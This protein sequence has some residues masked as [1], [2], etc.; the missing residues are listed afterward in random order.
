MYGINLINLLLITVIMDL[1]SKIENG[2]NGKSNI[3]N[4]RL[5]R[6]I[7]LILQF[8]IIAGP[9]MTMIDTSVVNI[10]LPEMASNFSVTLSVVQWVLSAYLLT[11][12]TFLVLS[13]YLSKRFGAIKVYSTSLIGF[14]VASFFCAVSPYLVVLIISRV[15][16]GAMGALLTPLAMDILFG[17]EKASKNMS[18]L[19]GIVL[20][21]APALGPTAGGFLIQ[22]FGWRSIFLIN[23]PVGIIS[24]LVMYKYRPLNSPMSG[25]TKRFDTLGIIT[26]G[27][28]IFLLLLASSDGPLYGW[29]SSFVVSLI[30]TG[31]A[32]IVIY[33]FISIRRPAPAVNFKVLKNRLSSLSVI[34]TSLAGV[35]LFS[36]IFL[37]PVYI[38]LTRG[39]SALTV[40]LILLPQGFITGIATVISNKW[41][42][43]PKGKLIIIIG[44]LL[45]TLSTIP[46]V[47][48]SSNA[49]LWLFSAILCVRGASLGLVIQPLLY[50]VIGNLSEVD[51]PDGNSL[52][53]IIERIGGAFG[54]S[55][56]A[57]VFEISE[58][59]NMSILHYSSLVAG[60]MAFHETM[61]ILV[62]V[63]FGG[64]IMSLFLL[65]ERKLH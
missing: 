25:E 4:L 3:D 23:I 34:I 21:M 60:T 19:I 28:G 42:S 20:F 50:Q 43:G 51:V 33:Y 5:H 65:K 36:V 7:P 35:V 57:S 16:Q 55:V 49:S 41:A 8:G 58:V 40:G 54:I 30:L 1:M 15:F 2:T 47:V 59:H 52:F 14:T 56:L 29:L 63:S 32:F 18:Y 38:E 53:N 46:L 44:M 17:K 22:S 61:L 13:P 6:K 37:L 27:S 9:F 45:L 31:V 39:F 26:F 64:F 48:I 62:Y 24:A 12:G 10:A 11:L